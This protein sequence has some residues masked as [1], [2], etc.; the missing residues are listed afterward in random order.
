MDEFVNILDPNKF[1]AT[2]GPWNS[3]R[4]NDPLSVGYVTFLIE[5]KTFTQKEEWESFYYKSG[6]Y[7]DDLLS[8]I[9]QSS[10]NIL[11]DES[12]LINDI[13]NK[14]IVVIVKRRYPHPFFDKV[15]TSSKKYLF[16]YLS[17]IFI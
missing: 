6:V 4:L 12:L 15:I 1:R 8:K 10:Q 14:T 7:R 11:S 16:L 17:V 9:D 3:L 2:N 5:L 13:N